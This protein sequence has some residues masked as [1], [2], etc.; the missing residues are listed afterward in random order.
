MLRAVQVSKQ[1]GALEGRL[2]A[3]TDSAPHAR[4]AKE[5]SCG[6]AGCFSAPFAIPLY[7]QAFEE[8]SGQDLMSC[9]ALFR[10]FVAFLSES[11]ARH[12]GL[13]LNSD[14]QGLELIEEDN[15][16]PQ[17]MPYIPGTGPDST[18]VPFLAGRKLRYRV[19]LSGG[20]IAQPLFL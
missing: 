16:I 8:D 17:S 20:A 19:Q 7:A 4:S 3:G 2:F 9:D 6:C 14:D 1:D 5:S 12:Y 10:L 13:P 18:I 15:H 11:G